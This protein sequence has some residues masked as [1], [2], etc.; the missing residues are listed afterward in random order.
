MVTVRPAG[1]AA[2]VGT[3]DSAHPTLRLRSPE[4]T[5]NGAGNLTAWLRGGTGSGSLNG[6]GVSALPANTTSPGFQG[7]ALR[8]VNTGN[9]LLSGKKSSSGDTW[10]QAVF[11]AA[12]LTALP[13][14]VYTLDLIDAGHGGWGWVAM[15]SVSIP[16]TPVSTHPP[17]LKVQRWT[18]NQVRI[19]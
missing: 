13:P 7:V 6:T 16:G 15:D 3:Q 19:S 2:Q 1:L 18:S 12:E 9:Y 17:T 11:T 14:G 5:L 8:N 4:F 10:Q